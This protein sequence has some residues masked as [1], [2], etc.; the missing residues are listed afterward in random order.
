[1]PFDPKFAASILDKGDR[2]L[3]AIKIRSMPYFRGE[4]KPPAPLRFYYM[5]KIPSK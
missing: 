3:M 4:V 5:L 2:F 1:L